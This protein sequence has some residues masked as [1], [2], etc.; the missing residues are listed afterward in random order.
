MKTIYVLCEGQAEQQ[1]VQELLADVAEKKG[2]YVY[3]PLITTK[4]AQRKFAGGVTSYSK[5]RKD[6]VTLCNHSEATVTSMFD[7]YGLPK[8]T[9]GYSVQQRSHD[10]WA[11][12][13]EKAVNE[14]IGTRNIH[15]NLVVHEFEALLFS[16][17]SVFS[18]YNKDV[19]R[20]MEKALTDA[21]GNPE[22]IN[23]GY[24]TSPSHRITSMYPGYSK[25]AIG[26]IMAKRMG[27]DK[28]RSSCQHFDEWL[29]SLGI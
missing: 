14:D 29:T 15:F 22:E 2:I 24:D 28:I 12:S 11:Y 27:L 9:P 7:L 21:H 26:V 18:D 20:V 19:V 10:V 17:P 13:I 6:L 5:I 3:A 25:P 1:F 8:D 16:N 4:V 23:S